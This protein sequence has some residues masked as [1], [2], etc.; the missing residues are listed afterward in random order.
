MN[1]PNVRLPIE[2]I[3]DW[4]NGNVIVY[5]DGE[6]TR[7]P[8]FTTMM[9]APDAHGDGVAFIHYREKNIVGISFMTKEAVRQLAS[10]LNVMIQ[11]FH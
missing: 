4:P 7:V 9:P 1:R 11:N 3:P 8:S 5:E 10:A 6:E 2:V